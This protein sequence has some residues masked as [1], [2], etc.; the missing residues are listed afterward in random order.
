MRKLLLA[1]AALAA[2]GA[3]SAMA[4]QI[5]VKDSGPMAGPVVAV[6]P[7]PDSV[8]SYVV[9]NPRPAVRL[10]GEI[11]QG[12]VVPG[13]V[14]LVPVPDNPDYVYF[15]AGDNRPVIVRAEDRS[16]VYVDAD[17]VVDD[18]IPDE[19]IGYVRDNPVDPLVLEGDI[20]VGYE[21][22]VDARLQPVDGY[23]G[24]SYF[25]HNGQPYVVDQTSRRVVYYP[26]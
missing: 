18:G 21:V 10:E 14:E 3:G 23:K 19:L 24:Y 17:T 16:V 7:A 20:A 11:V 12:Y 5:V 8:R 1:T 22:P 13:D 26:R 9:A 25:Y 15:Y 4:D 2:L 6:V